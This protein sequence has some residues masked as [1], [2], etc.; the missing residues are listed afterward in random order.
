[1]ETFRLLRE[2]VQEIHCGDE[3]DELAVRGKREK[4]AIGSGPLK[5]H[6]S[7][8][9]LM[10][11][12][13]KFFEQSE[14]VHQLEVRDEWCRRG[15]RERNPRA[16]RAPSRPR[17]RARVIAGIIPLARRRLLRSAFGFRR[18][19]IA[20]IRSKKRIKKRIFCLSIGR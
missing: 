14:L 20:V 12:S 3:R 18:E 19:V 16:S 15:N 17:R 13:E 9:V 1:V 2:K 6:G 10:W 5:C 11:Q 4:S 8:A 7:P